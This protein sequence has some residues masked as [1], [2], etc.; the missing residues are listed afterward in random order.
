MFIKG[1][2][3][4]VLARVAKNLAYTLERSVSLTVAYAACDRFLASYFI[5]SAADIFDVPYDSMNFAKTFLRPSP[6][7]LKLD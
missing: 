4:D 2:S 6:I 3:S 7:S 1:T 5:F